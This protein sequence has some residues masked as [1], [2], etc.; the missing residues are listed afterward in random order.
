M[1]SLFFLT[2]AALPLLAQ[3]DEVP[4]PEGGPTCGILPGVC[5]KKNLTEEEK[6]ALRDQ[7]M[8]KF[9][10]DG[11]GRLSDEE[12]AAGEN[13]FASR[14]S[15]KENRSAGMKGCPNKPVDAKPVPGYVPHK[16]VCSRCRKAS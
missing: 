14:K 5:G 6:D 9:D 3:T 10:R 7:I 8:Q 2:L 13:F 15:A 4:A 12:K 16:P 11:D 1:K